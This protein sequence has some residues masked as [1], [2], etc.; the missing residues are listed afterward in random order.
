MRLYLVW[1]TSLGVAVIASI[2]GAQ[3]PRA[4]PLKPTSETLDADFVGITSVRE[5]A[6]GQAIITDGRDQTLYLA[7]F[8][9]RTA[10][11]LG[12]KGR[13]PL[14]WLGVGFIHAIA[15]DSSI[16]SDF[17]NL[18]WLLFDGAKI[19]ATV[20][21]DNAAVRAA[22]AGI[23][24][25]DRF[26]HVMREESPPPRPGTT[27]FTRADSNALVFVDRRSGKV[28]TVARLRVRPHRRTNTMD[29]LGRVTSSMPASTEPNAQAELAHL[30]RDGWLAVV[31]LEPLRVDWR[32]PTGEWLRGKPFP[33]A[34]ENVDAAERRAIL[35]R[36]A[37]ARDDAKRMGFPPPADVAFPTTIPVL[38]NAAI[39]RETGDGRLLLQ[40][41][42]SAR[43]PRIRYLII[44]RRGTI[45]SEISVGAKES[46][47]GFGA[48]TIYIAFK[49]DDDVQRIRRHPWP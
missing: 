35:K 25:V 47:V 5:L 44:N 21:P 2:A 49:D 30:C 7:N 16:L 17:S 10:T 15:G 32:S 27:V 3:Q 6:D 33:I 45:D 36:R 41:S 1:C 8:R 40:R 20:P 37:E 11:V 24:G 29:S 43:N 13:G 28:D 19:V 18:R 38:S 42:S 22:R 26:G 4:L 23:S 31:R 39:L 46:I 14:E 48:S 9:S 34:P 12:R